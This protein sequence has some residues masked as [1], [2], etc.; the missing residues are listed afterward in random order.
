MKIIGPKFRTGDF[1]GGISDGVDSASSKWSMANR[2]RNRSGQ[3][4]STFNQDRSFRSGAAD[5]RAR[6]R[7]GI[8]RAMFGRF[9][10]SIATGGLVGV[11]AWFLV[12]VIESIALVS[13]IVAFL[14]TIADG[15][16]FLAWQLEADFRAA[17]P[18]EDRGGGFGGGSS[19]GGFSGGGGSFGGGG[20]SGS[21]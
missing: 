13:G 3:R 4:P 12:G 7:G 18:P 2:C 15:R 6:G 8:L 1:T 20:A 10:G 5:W 21:W 9:L 11:V 17:S 16:H 19:S 14:F